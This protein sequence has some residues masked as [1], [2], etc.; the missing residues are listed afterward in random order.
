[1]S[2]SLSSLDTPVALLDMP[3]MQRNIQRMQQ[4]MNELGVRLRPH[5]KTS[6]SLPVIQAQIAAGAIG[7]TVSTLKEAEHCFA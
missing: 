2:A 5:V 4:R 6:K 1:M 7:V 3:R